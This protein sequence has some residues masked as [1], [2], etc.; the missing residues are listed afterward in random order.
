MYVSVCMLADGSWCLHVVAS[1]FLVTGFFP[2]TYLVC[3]KSECF[4]DCVLLSP[5]GVKDM[6]SEMCR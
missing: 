4:G 2:L 5:F 6:G 3:S 1:V